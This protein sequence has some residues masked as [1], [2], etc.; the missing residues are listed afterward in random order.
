M[1]IKKIGHCCLL[2]RS[3]SGDNPLILTD[4]GSFSVAQNKLRGI[5]A[6][7]ITHEH[8]DHLHIKS[9]QEI[10]KNNPHA[11]VIANEGVGKK[12]DKVNI[13]HRRMRD[14]DTAEIKR[15]SIEAYD[16]KHEEIFEEI[17]QVQNTAFL[18]AGKLL[19]PGDSFFKPPTFVDILA[20]P[21]AGPWCKIGDAIRYALDVHPA[22]AFPIH[23][24]MLQRDRV[25]AAFRIPEQV[26]KKN[27]IN[28]VTLEEGQ[29]HN[30]LFAGF[31]DEK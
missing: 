1:L 22:I 4:P 7:L 24:G 23:D 6:V 16:A 15:V 5:D 25:G 13:P 2:I 9:L 31:K 30:F 17:G 29:E 10:L 21:V 20:L 26:L 11:E 14:R 18:I 19:I 28:F 27:D 12:L 8:E 3:G